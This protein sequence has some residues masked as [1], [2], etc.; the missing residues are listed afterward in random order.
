ML[1]LTL[2]LTTGAAYADDALEA[3]A[4]I[5]EYFAAFNDKDTARVSTEIYASP[6]HIGG[7][8]GNRVLA[9]PSDAVANLENLYGQIEAQGWVESVIDRIE[10]CV[11]SDGLVFADVIYSRIDDDGEP[12]P[13]AVRTNVYVLRETEDGWR[14]IA[15]YGHDNDKGLDC[16]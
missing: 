11:L 10:S 15:F 4:K 8:G 5:H 6:V 7:A 16:D 14:I 13:P 12:I 1:G 2:L 9:T 3:A